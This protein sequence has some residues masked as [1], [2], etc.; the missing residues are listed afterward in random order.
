MN[1]STAR[2]FALTKR[3]VKEILRDPTSLVF[4]ALLPVAMLVLMQ[5]LFAKMS[6]HAVMFRI[7]NF[8]PGI[9]TFGFTFTMLYVALTVSGDRKS[10]FMARITVSP[11]R[12]A[13][14][15]ISFILASVPVMIVQ[16]ILFYCVAFIFGLPF[17]TGVL[18]SVLL[19]IPSTF[20]Y[21]TAG[22]LIGSIADN[23]NQAGPISSIIISGAGLLGG[24]WLPIE[25]MSEGFIT[26]CKCLP[27]YNCVLA[28]KTPFVGGN[29][30]VPVLITIGYAVVFF[31]LSV[32]IH[33][34]KSKT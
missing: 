34:I 6:E 4:C 14:Y 3:N 2:V 19:L 8:A 9:T 5:V 29:A 17:G 13:E 30:L 20:F 27:F 24:V 18:L 25:T 12:P 33:K 32:V 28:G 10:A 23:P 16:T 1:K 7:E 31:V 22:T 15:V 21:A 11:V 26:V